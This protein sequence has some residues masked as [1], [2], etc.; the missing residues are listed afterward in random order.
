M[1][2]VGYVVEVQ[3]YFDVLG[4]P[5]YVAY[6]AL[7]HCRKEAKGG[8]NNMIQIQDATVIKVDATHLTLELGTPRSAKA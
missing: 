3:F 2:Y 8:Y 7:V 6:T 1:G 5:I 4:P